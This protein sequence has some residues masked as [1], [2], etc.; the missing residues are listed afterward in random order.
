MAFSG[1]GKTNVNINHSMNTCNNRNVRRTSFSNN[2]DNSQP[3]NSGNLLNN[4]NICS[5]NAANSTSDMS[6]NE[7]SDVK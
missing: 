4:A 3:V 5:N 7:V 6:E 2:S 1:N